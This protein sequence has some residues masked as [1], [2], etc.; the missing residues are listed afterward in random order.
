MN[1]LH[2]TINPISLER[3]IL[4]QV[5]SA[6][7]H[8]HVVSVMY[9]KEDSGKSG[10]A[11]RDYTQIPLKTSFHRGGPLKFLQYNWKVLRAGLNHEFDIIHAHDLWILPAATILSV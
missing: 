1:I 4:N 7:Q 5:R 6:I 3:R 9:L 10:I 11:N 2:I 8:S